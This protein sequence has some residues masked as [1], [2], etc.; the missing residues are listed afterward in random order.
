[1]S[2]YLR[3]TLC[4]AVES[5]VRSKLDAPNTD[6]EPTYSKT[7]LALVMPYTCCFPTRRPAM[8]CSVESREFY[9]AQKLTPKS[10]PA[11]CDIYIYKLSS[12]IPETLR[13]KL[14]VSV[15]DVEFLG[16]LPRVDYQNLVP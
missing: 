6:R 5:F 10:E 2:D 15:D 7:G 1:M 11:L 12:P 4:A 8:K 3:T 13:H 14:E 16:L 9:L